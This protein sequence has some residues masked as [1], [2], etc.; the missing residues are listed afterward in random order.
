[1]QEKGLTAEQLASAK[2]YVK[3]TYAPNRLQTAD[4]I[5]GE[6]GEIELFGLGA[7]EVNQFFQRIDAVT[8]EEANGVAQ[9]DYRPEGL[10]FILVGNAARIRD[11]AAKYGP[12]VVERPAT[13]PGWTGM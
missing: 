13:Q 9:R 2:A 6:L 12:K 4:Q 8:L 10:T 3:G 11:V 7:D 5:A 1:L